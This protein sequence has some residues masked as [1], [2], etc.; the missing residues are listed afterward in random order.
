MLTSGDETSDPGV[1][2]HGCDVTPP[3]EFAACWVAVGVVSATPPPG[4]LRAAAGDCSPNKKFTIADDTCWVAT[5]REM[6][7]DTVGETV[8]EAVRDK[9]ERR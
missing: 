7:R 8:R 9:V 6:V 2:A 4:V 5:V 3:T 1:A